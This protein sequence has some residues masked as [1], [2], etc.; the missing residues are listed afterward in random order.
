MLTDYYGDVIC[1]ASFETDRLVFN[2]DDQETAYN[3]V[4]EC[5]MEAIENLEKSSTDAKF[6]KDKFF[7]NG[8]INKWKNLQIL[9][10]QDTTITS[11]TNLLIN[12]ILLFLC[13]KRN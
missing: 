2:H 11:Q 4:R 6:A 13:R 5:A 12:P 3:K 9:F 7:Y 1:E 8:D 10:W